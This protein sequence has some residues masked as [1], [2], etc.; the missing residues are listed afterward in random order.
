MTVVGEMRREN[1]LRRAA[2][3]NVSIGL[4]G[5]VAT[6]R[7]HVALARVRPAPVHLDAAVRLAKY[8]TSS[9]ELQSKRLRDGG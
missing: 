1:L 7:R 3:G 2:L 8:V 4:V 9:G 5:A 6:A